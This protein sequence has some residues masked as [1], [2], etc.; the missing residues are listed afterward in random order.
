MTRERDPG[1]AGRG[2]PAPAAA[3]TTSYG[4]ARPDVAVSV[5]SVDVDWVAR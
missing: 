4:D 1:V 3:R 5:R 2:A